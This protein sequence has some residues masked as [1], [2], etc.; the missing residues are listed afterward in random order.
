MKR[1]ALLVLG[2]SLFAAPALA[3]PVVIHDH[4]TLALSAAG[5]K[6][7]DTESLDP[8]NLPK[9]PH[10]TVIVRGADGKQIAQYD[11][12][13]DCKYTDIAWSPKG[14]VFAFI[15]RGVGKAT[16]YLVEGGKLRT[17]TTITGVANTVRFSP[18][19]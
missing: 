17:L 10:G 11:P 1:L 15:G 14:D 2:S 18:D 12:C 7:A 8:G 9:E 6:V 5:D 4:D 3:A 16:L 13:K 19:G